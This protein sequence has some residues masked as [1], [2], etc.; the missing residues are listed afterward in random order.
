MSCMHVLIPDALSDYLD[1]ALSNKGVAAGTCGTNQSKISSVKSSS[2][3]DKILRS[4]SFG[5]GTISS[6]EK[7]REVTPKLNT[8]GS[9]NLRQSQ[10]NLI[11]VNDQ[12]KGGKKMQHNSSSQSQKT[13]NVF[14]GKRFR[15][16]D[17]F[18][19]DRVSTLNCVS[20]ICKL[21]FKKIWWFCFIA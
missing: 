19:K 10:Q 4:E 20:N 11:S 3:P 12:R 13:L 21:Y 14:K 2:H 8:S 7:N 18:P 16:S 5:D 1:S 6:L 9:A 15:F 17:S